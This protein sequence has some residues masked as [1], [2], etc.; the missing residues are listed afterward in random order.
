VAFLFYSTFNWLVISLQFQCYLIDN[1]T[2]IHNTPNAFSL[3]QPP[4][5]YNLQTL[6]VFKEPVNYKK[7]TIKL[8]LKL[9][10]AL[11]INTFT[12]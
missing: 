2:K 9:L 7:S 3:N 8:G 11:Q 4:L 10:S 1:S 5:T 6:N 12:A